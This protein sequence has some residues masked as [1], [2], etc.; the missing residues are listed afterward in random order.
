M[1][2]KLV[3]NSGTIYIVWTD[4]WIGLPQ[5]QDVTLSKS[6]NN[7]TTFTLPKNIESLFGSAYEPKLVKQ[8][9]NVYVVWKNDNWENKDVIDI[10]NGNYT[11]DIFLKQIN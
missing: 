2:L 9:E 8:G 11:T 6:Y 7:G 5:I 3:D 10:E 1:I 4:L